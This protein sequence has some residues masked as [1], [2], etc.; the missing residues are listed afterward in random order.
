[1]DGKK[2]IV[3][4]GAGFGG[5]KAARALL[6]GLRKLDL[7]GKYQ[8][9]L[10][11]R[12]EYQTYY[13][14]LYE[15]ATTSKNLANQL[16]LKHIVTIPLAEIFQ[17]K[18]LEFVKGGVV[19]LDLP[20]GDIHLADGRTQRF[21]YLVLALGSEPNYFNI[22][23]LQEHA[24]AFKTFIDAV[25]VRDAIWNILSEAPADKRVRIIIGGGGATGVELAGEVQAWICELEQQKISTC[26][27]SVTIVEAAPTVLNHFDPRVVGAVTRR[28]EKLGVALATGEIIQEVTPEH[29]AL[30]SGKELDYDVFVWTGGVKSPALMA[31]LP[32]KKEKHGKTEVAGGMACTPQ[33][34]DLKLYG[35]IYGIGDS[36]C[37]VNPKTQI[38]VP[39]L[40]E[41]AIGQA[42][43][44]AHNILEEIKVAEGVSKQ[45]KLKQYRPA[46]E[47][48]YVIPAGGKYAVAKVGPLILTGF[49]GWL[50]KGLIELYY[51]L[52]NVLPPLQ[53]FSV[54]FHGLRIFIQNDRLG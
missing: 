36:V 37:F 22:P 34:P 51:L 47:F 18:P 40:A 29:A 48:S 35:K 53:A 14:T 38:P 23:G 50:L 4:L 8:V 17:G 15:V 43:I 24:L 52:F 21:D 33:T 46:D 26:R 42:R 27:A 44:A 45:V 30:K 39:Q 19:S 2:Q 12:H 9:V 20:A 5:I 54:W 6:D 16:D 49:F 28:L 13:P 1:M 7:L 3:I 11:D 32:L 41:A 25:K 31:D 10:I